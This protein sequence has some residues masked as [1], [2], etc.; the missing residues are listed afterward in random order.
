M[1]LQK[2]TVQELCELFKNEASQIKEKNFKAMKMKIGMGPKED[3]KLVSAVRDT[4]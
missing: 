2:K 1:M 3:L 4:I